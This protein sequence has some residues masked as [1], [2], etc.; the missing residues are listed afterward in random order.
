MKTIICI[1]F[2]LISVSLFSQKQTT[3]YF[4]FTCDCTKVNTS[5]N[6]KRNSWSFEYE[7]VKDEVLIAIDVKVNPKKENYPKE[8]IDKLVTD[9]GYIKTTIGSFRN[10]Y[11]T[12]SVGQSQGYYLRKSTFNS[13]YRMY[14][15]SVISSNKRLSQT[16]FN[17]I[18]ESFIIK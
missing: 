11:A 2:L 8:L 15:V 7:N 5:H 16:I 1:T 17:Q 14:I 13:N 9:L 10:L 6:S 12:V 3:A 18:E 4:E